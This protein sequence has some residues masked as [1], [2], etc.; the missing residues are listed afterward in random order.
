[1]LVSSAMALQAHNAQQPL[2]VVEL[3]SR[4]AGDVEAAAA[5]LY[6]GRGQVLF[7][8]PGARRA[9]WQLDDADGD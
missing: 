6:G 5:A 4:L 7:F 3:S 9:A 8:P 1:M 2:A